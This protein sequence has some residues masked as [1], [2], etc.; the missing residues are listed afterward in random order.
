MSG[1]ER[2]KVFGLGLSRTGTRSLTAAL[3]VL[4]FDTV[5]YPI[6]KATLDTLTRGDAKFPLLDHFDGITDITTIPYLAELDELHPGAKFVL[7]V[8]DLPGWLKSCSNHWTGRSA[9]EP[10]TDPEHGVHMEIRRFLRAAVYGCYDF[11]AER[12]ARVYADH[13]DRVKR[14]FAS[15]PND[16]LVLDIVAGDG[17]DKLA[18]FLG[19]PLPEQQSFPHKGKKLSERMNQGG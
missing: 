18:P 19:V 4:G 1:G 16:L 8:R 5:H 7:T 6:D 14:Y 11:H 3:H 2:S 13:V 9:F 17:F 10:A 15:R 12:F